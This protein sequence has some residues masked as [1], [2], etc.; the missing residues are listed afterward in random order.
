[1]FGRSRKATANKR[2]VRKLN[3]RPD[4]AIFDHYVPSRGD[5]KSFE[6][7]IAKIRKDRKKNIGQIHDEADETTDLT[8]KEWEIPNLRNWSFDVPYNSS[9]LY[10]PSMETVKTIPS[11]LQTMKQSIPSE[12]SS[13]DSHRKSPTQGSYSWTSPPRRRKLPTPSNTTEEHLARVPLSK[14]KRFYRERGVRETLTGPENYARWAKDMKHRLVQCNAWP[15]ISENMSPVPETSSFYPVWTDLNKQS[16]FL[17]LNS[18]SGEISRDIIV[19]SD[20]TTRGAWFYLQ[21]TYASVSATTLCSVQGVRDMLDI[22][23]EE[24]ASMKDFLGLMVQCFHAIEC[25]R[26]GKRDA[27]WLWCQVI[28]MKLGPK[29]DGWVANL[30]DKVRIRDRALDPFPYEVISFNDITCKDQTWRTQVTMS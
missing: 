5:L 11:S 10:E 13:C 12:I 2:P 26:K 4:A 1:M 19:N 22:K 25:N 7:P 17:L 27:E 3:K 18:V 28:L 30:L 14:M 6:R 8:E 9:K 23:Y 15:I 21:K 29:W 24:C 20:W 16:W